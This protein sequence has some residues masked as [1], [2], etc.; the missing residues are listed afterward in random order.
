MAN[1]Q[2]V[3]L[4]RSI[5]SRR[6]GRGPC[7]VTEPLNLSR[8]KLA[9]LELGDWID[10]GAE[11]PRFYVREGEGYPWRVRFD[12]RDGTIGAVLESDGSDLL[13]ERPGK[14]RIA[15]EGWVAH[16][17]ELPLRGGEW[18]PFGWNPLEH[19]LLAT[20]EGPFAEGRIVRTPDGFAI[21]ITERL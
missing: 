15:A 5:L 4:N 16:L 21:E 20:D 1:V 3:P 9:A 12:E 13:W 19:L 10:L 7:I 8:R 17:G 11:E 14:K 18:I 6:C 2:L